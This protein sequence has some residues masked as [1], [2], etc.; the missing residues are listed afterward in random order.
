MTDSADPTVLGLALRRRLRE[1][2]IDSGQS[3]KE[4]AQSLAWAPTKLL[5]LEN[6][7]IGITPDELGAVLA[8]FGITDDQPVR[9]L[10]RIAREARRVAAGGYG[11][12]LNKELQALLRWETVAVTIHQFE[13][14]FIP[15]LLQTREYAEAILRL[16]AGP[17]DSP[18]DV[19]RRVEARMARQILL[20]RADGPQLS[21]IL[22]ESVFHRWIG[23]EAGQGPA[24][25]RRQIEHL[26][27]LAENPRVTIRVLPY[28]VG[29]HQGLKGPFVILEFAEPAVGE[30]LYLEDSEGD[31]IGRGEPVDVSPYYERFWAME[32]TALPGERFGDFLDGLLWDTGG[33]AETGM[34]A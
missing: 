18:A 16:F 32:E 21:V 4:V 23:A 1:L 9:E 34:A 17:Q 10:H 12:V 27:R 6:G 3:Y 28:E 7:E 22:D 19:E 15:G 25:M 24:L 33:G 2:R 26:R 30:M 13:P 29:V 14:T 20:D 31:F 11:G 8:H 5:R